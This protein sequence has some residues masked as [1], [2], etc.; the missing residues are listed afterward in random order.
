MLLFVQANWNKKRRLACE[1]VIEV[2]KSLLKKEDM[3]CWGNTRHGELGLGGIED[4]IILVPCEVDFKKAS[5][6]QQSKL[7]YNHMFMHTC[8]Y[9]YRFSFNC[10]Y[11]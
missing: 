2:Q 11:L 5:E 1:A 6:I 10:L 4:E 7:I 8:I 9:V 3:F